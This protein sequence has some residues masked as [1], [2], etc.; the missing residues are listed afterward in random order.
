MMIIIIYKEP[1][2]KYFIPFR[3]ILNSLETY[4]IFYFI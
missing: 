4:H 3:L 2:V 1:L